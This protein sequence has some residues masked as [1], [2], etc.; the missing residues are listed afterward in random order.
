MNFIF[1]WK[2][3]NYFKRREDPIEFDIKILLNNWYFILLELFLFSWGGFKIDLTFI[4]FNTDLW[5]IDPYFWLKDLI[6]LGI[7]A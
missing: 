4:Y 7:T 5:L 3:L 6:T 2:S 1:K